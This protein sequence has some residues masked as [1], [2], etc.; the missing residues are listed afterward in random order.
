VENLKGLKFV[1]TK[2]NSVNKNQGLTKY[3]CKKVFSKEGEK[4]GRVK[5]IIFNKEIIEGIIVAKS[6]FFRKIFIDMEYVDKFTSDSVLLNIN[7]LILIVGKRVFDN[8]GKDLGKVKKVIRK[9]NANVIDSILVKKSIF[10]KD[11]VIQPK[12]I[13]FIKK[14]IRLKISV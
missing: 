14:N 4:I 8:D 9:S 12:D 5:Q 7:P 2:K 13:H 6:L 1:S 10:S 11:V 3:L